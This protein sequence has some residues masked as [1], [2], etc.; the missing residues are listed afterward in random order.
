MFGFGRKLHVTREIGIAPPTP[1]VGRNGIAIVC[2]I[3]NEERYI[4]EWLRFHRSVGVRHFILYNDGS[5]DETVD[6][7]RKALR[8]DEFTIIPWSMRMR[9]EASGEMLN[10]QTIA[11]T[12][13]IL[14]FGGQFSHMA[15][16]DVDEFL[17]PKSGSTLQEALAGA[18]GF[19]NISLPWHMFGHGGHATQPASAVPAAYTKRVADPMQRHAHA[20]NF[21]CIVDPTEVTH[22]SVHHFQT[23]SHGDR[24]AN[25]AGNIVD[26]RARKDADFY[27]NRFI[28]LNHY[29]SRSKEEFMRKIDRGCSYDAVSEKY[30]E[31]AMSTIAYLENNPVE[32]RA[33]IEFLERHDIDLLGR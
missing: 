12:H 23:R 24:T 26:R 4:G 9:D 20:F 33:M 29:Y 10:A 6:A 7:I 3:K 17:L 15:F 18:Q 1:E 27:S 16:I 31:K 32:D 28:Q 5:T 21:K 30:R 22:V 13:A 11:F 14:N 25:D 2:W 19:P 8:Q